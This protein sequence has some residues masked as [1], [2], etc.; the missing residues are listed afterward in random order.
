MSSLRSIV[1]S[2][3]LATIVAGGCASSHATEVSSE[4]QN[5]PTTT[6]R[7]GTATLTPKRAAV[8]LGQRMLDDARLPDGARVSTA[9]SPAHLQGPQV[10]PAMGN[11][12]YAHRFWSVP[13]SPDAVQRWLQAHVPAG[14]K[15]SGTGTSSGP[16]YRIVGVQDDLAS[17]PA[18]ISTAEMQVAIV[19]DGNNS[20]ARVDTLVGW[21]GPRPAGEFV[22][23][24]DHGVTVRVVRAYAP[25]R[26]VTK[27]IVVTDPKV[28]AR[29]VHAFNALAVAPPYV[30]HSCPMISSGTVSYRV[31]FATATT[32]PPDVTANIGLCGPVAV[33]VGGHT[34]PS[35]TS[36]SAFGAAVAHALGL[37]EP[38]FN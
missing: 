3:A 5:P 27:T 22:S 17:L 36:S 4:T 14:F 21:T 7:V 6:I 35:L 33:S 20:I 24:N 29:I 34:A 8:A 15:A 23:A 13:G 10:R 25:G 16:G 1:S 19:P 32:A 30:V 18:N 26:P 31:E 28:V 12:V 11:L 37:P 2:V 38:H 9:P